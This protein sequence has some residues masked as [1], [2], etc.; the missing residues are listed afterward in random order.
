MCKKS[1]QMALSF[2]DVQI[3]FRIESV[4]EKKNL[5]YYAVKKTSQLL[6]FLISETSLNLNDINVFPS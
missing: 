4:D 3:Y 5:S 2:N 6:Y 1:R